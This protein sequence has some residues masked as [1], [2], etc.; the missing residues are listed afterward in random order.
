MVMLSVEVTTPLVV[1]LSVVIL[2]VLSVLS[3]VGGF[4]AV[5]DPV[6][7]RWFGGLV[8][9]RKVFEKGRVRPLVLSDD[10]DS[11]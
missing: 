7:G 1:T 9:R 2:S 5:S 3:V 8:R 10:V 6:C 4:S 11:T